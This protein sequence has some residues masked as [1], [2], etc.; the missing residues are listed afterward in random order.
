ME[1]I[2]TALLL[3][4]AGKEINEENMKKVL[5]S[6]GISKDDSQIKALVSAL[7]DMNIE[8]AIKEAAKVTSAPA[9][10]Q[11]APK[12]EEKKEEKQEEG[13]SAEAAAAGL[14]SLFG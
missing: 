2:Y 13:K 9:A 8:E 3:H 4:K 10:T 12:A 14:S 11:E 1:L 5:E 7:K 6:A